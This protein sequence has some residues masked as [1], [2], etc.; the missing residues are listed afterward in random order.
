MRP[1]RGLRVCVCVCG[2]E[3]TASPK[4][5]VCVCGRIQWEGGSA[6]RRVR[7]IERVFEAFRSVSRKQER[8][9]SEGGPSP[10][11]GAAAALCTCTSHTSAVAVVLRTTT[12]TIADDALGEWLARFNVL[13]CCVCVCVH[14]GWD[15]HGQHM[16][17]ARIARRH[18][19]TR[20][21]AAQNER[22]NKNNRRIVKRVSSTDR[23]GG[24][25]MATAS[26][27]HTHTHTN[28]QTE[29]HRRSCDEVNTFR[30]ATRDVFSHPHRASQGYEGAGRTRPG[31]RQPRSH[32]RARRSPL[33]RPAASSTPPVSRFRGRTRQS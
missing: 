31:F 18:T 26:C 20:V 22:G 2:T 28:T 32:R 21:Q 14:E 19:H 27:T 25:R 7:R 6:N 15:T 30:V 11:D 12:G 10:R 3:C 1:P 8:R 23:G 13:H 5:Y 29:Q 33:R 9:R 17:L 4:L 16:F 24:Q